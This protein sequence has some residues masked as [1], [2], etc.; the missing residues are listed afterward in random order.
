MNATEPV[1]STCIPPP[2]FLLVVVTIW[3]VVPQIRKLPKVPHLH[4]TPLAFLIA[5]G[6]AEREIKKKPQP[7]IKC[8]MQIELKDSSYY[9]LREIPAHLALPPASPRLPPSHPIPS[10][11]PIPLPSAGAAQP[12]P[13]GAAAPPRC[14]ARCCRSPSHGS[15]FSSISSP[16]LG[17]LTYEKRLKDSTL[18][19][20]LH[21]I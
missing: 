20:V 18:F 13:G 11:T 14:A 3:G 1:T 6:K 12:L 7:H 2:A 19:L 9:W 17:D 16:E 4:P 8:A 5:K 10:P 15:L 21:D